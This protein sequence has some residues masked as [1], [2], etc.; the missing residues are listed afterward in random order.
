M[1]KYKISRN[2]WLVAGFCFLITL[3]LNLSH[4]KLW[5]LPILNGFACILCF[6]NVYIYHKKA[7]KDNED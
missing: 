5:I 6:V 2:L 7:I 1:N 3:I 4:N